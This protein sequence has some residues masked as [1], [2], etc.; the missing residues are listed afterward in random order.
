MEDLEPYIEDVIT[1]SEN[2]FD[3]SESVI[4]RDE[5]ILTSEYIPNKLIGRREQVEKIAAL[6]NPVF[7]RG[8]PYNCLIY[9]KTGSGKT[10]VT[11]FVLE[12][13]LERVAVQSTIDYDLRWVYIPCKQIKTTNDVLTTIIKY[14]NPNNSI[15][16]KGYSLNVYY[17][18]LWKEITDSNLSLIV[19]LDEIDQ[20]K[21]DEI[22]YQLSR[23]GEMGNIPSRR[24]IAI[25]GI[26]NDLNYVEKLD[27]RVRSS[28]NFTDII[29]EPYDAIQIT[30]ILKDRIILALHPGVISETLIA[31]CAS[32][33][34]KSN[35]DARL[36]IDLVRTSGGIAAK[37]KCS[38][39]TKQHVDEAEKILAENRYLVLARDLPVHDKLLL[40][41]I[42]KVLNIKSVEKTT[43]IITSVYIELC[44]ECMQEPLNR[45]TISN[46]ISEFEMLGFLVTKKLN[47]GRAGG[48]TRQV[49]LPNNV[50][51]NSLMDVLY[52]DY[53]VEE[54][55]NFF[56]NIN[57][58][59]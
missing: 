12:R 31:I 39:I 52:S 17:N 53:I 19:V 47:R 44:K 54:V 30:S 10:V 15:P 34:A 5:H 45:T 22:L 26:S 16:S 50:P 38:V 11:K 7:R 48:V 3:E 42:I 18:V 32:R 13:L 21:N 23:A 8:K 28:A 56:P 27:P 55:K 2:I 14:L 29:F 49:E 35:G 1:D 4:F 41:A 43:S 58:W 9:G 20:L 59:L 51:I 57:M 40:V 36:A 33:S 6:I 25:F 24:F 37:E 46:K